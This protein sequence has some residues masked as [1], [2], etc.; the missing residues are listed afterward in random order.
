MGV[1]KN[2]SRLF[3]WFA[4]LQQCSQA[5]VDNNNNNN[6]CGLCES[7]IESD[8]T[9]LNINTNVQQRVDIAFTAYCFDVNI[10]LWG[11]KWC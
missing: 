3:T 8:E 7:V 5:Y 2:E 6:T 10:I 4:L 1:W 9:I 11:L